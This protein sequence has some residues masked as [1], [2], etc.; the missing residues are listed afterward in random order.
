MAGERR[1]QDG[2]DLVFGHS[3]YYGV[4]QRAERSVAMYKQGSRDSL[5]DKAD[6]MDLARQQKTRQLGGHA[7]SSLELQSVSFRLT[8]P[9]LCPLGFV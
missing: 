9:F 4:V 2:V 3:V 8:D 1:S 7:L 5:V 6:M